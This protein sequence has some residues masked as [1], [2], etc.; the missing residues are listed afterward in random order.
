MNCCD[1]K[2]HRVIG[3]TSLKSLTMI[4]KS[5]TINE[6]DLQFVK[7]STLNPSHF[8]K[9]FLQVE[10]SWAIKLYNQ[11]LSNRRACSTNI[12]VDQD[13]AQSQNNS[14]NSSLAPNVELAFALEDAG[15]LAQDE[16]SGIV[17]WNSAQARWLPP[18]VDFEMTIS[19]ETSWGPTVPISQH[20]QHQLR[21]M[22]QAQ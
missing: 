22:Q 10:S 16:V 11:K 6:D 12:W 13:Q 4:Q 21:H 14:Q 7:L 19:Q 9:T 1:H 15:L 2:N 20:Q 3:F 17:G 8:Q 18:R 5:F